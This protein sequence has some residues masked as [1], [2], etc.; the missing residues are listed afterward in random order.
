LLSLLEED[1][2]TNDEIAASS[3]DA[4]P[5]VA[6]LAAKRLGGKAP[7]VVRGP[8]LII[9]DDVQLL[10]P[11]ASPTTIK[12]ALVAMDTAD[13]SRG[14]LLFMAK[15][16]ANCTIC[17]QMEG[18][19]NIHAPGLSDIGNRADATA[20]ITSILDPSANITEGFAMQMLTTKKGA[21]YGGILLEETGR[22]LR[23][24]LV[25]GDEVTVDTADLAQRSSIDV[26]AMPA[27]FAAMLT[28]QQ[29]ADIAAYLRSLKSTAAS[30]AT[31][32][33][34]HIDQKD[35]PLVIAL[36]GQDIATYYFSHEQTKRPFFA[37][38]KTPG[39]IQVT[40]N[41]PPVEG[42]D[43]V[44]HGY[45]HPGLSLGFALLNGE[46]FWHNDRGTVV[47]EA[48]LTNPA[49]TADSATFS[50]RNR[51][52]A[53]DGT[54]ICHETASYR[55]TRN[56]DGYLIATEHAFTSPEPFYF[57]VKEEMGLAVRF[58]SPIRVKEAAGTILNS[59]N[60]INEKGTW[61]K[62]ADWW[63]YSGTIDDRH[64]GIQIMSAVGNPPAWSHS[65]DY[66]VLV[67][68]PFPVDIKENRDKQVAVEPGQTFTLKFGVQIH[69]N[70][71]SGTYNPAAAWERFQPGRQ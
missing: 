4:D 41:F 15:G 28:P 9:K 63:D 42:V 14:R 47:H 56:D 31:A 36:D 48:F 1:S 57:G 60:G 71:S 65:R 52:Q 35:G 54:T 49:A 50:V 18:I 62:I 13:A 8:S 17:H 26:S 24:A 40:R 70:E 29:V 11:P 22:S 43:P 27:T 23:L 21:A 39:G 58:A 10:S 32:T 69:E 61:G 34:F 44:D 38:L 64:V 5:V 19:G 20:I 16:G 45:L 46:N 37:H 51:Y 25:N 30:T 67:A 53:T 2:L 33:G 12:D 7:V 6:A 66:G 68:N 55:I 59:N 3:Q